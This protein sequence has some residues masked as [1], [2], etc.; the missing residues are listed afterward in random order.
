MT[1][2]NGVSHPPQVGSAFGKEEGRVRGSGLLALQA[3][4]NGTAAR[5]TIGCGAFRRR[6]GRLG[7]VALSCLR[8]HLFSTGRGQ[9]MFEGPSLTPREA[10]ARLGIPASTLRAHATEFQPLLSADARDTSP[11]QDRTF[12]HRRYSQADLDVLSRAQTLLESGLSYA[13]AR[14]QLGLP[15]RE[16]TRARQLAS[17]R[18]VRRARPPSNRTT[19]QDA[20]R[21]Q[22]LAALAEL[23]SQATTWTA[24]LA[25]AMVVLSRGVRTPKVRPPA[26]RAVARAVVGPCSGG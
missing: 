1:S 9:A 8:K 17:N 25:G 18:S 23:A 13:A 12:R 3:A 24:R 11:G 6:G 15:S 4:G 10:A 26:L 14:E 16:V 20:P 21:A 5:L 2:A 7:F 19:K 22:E